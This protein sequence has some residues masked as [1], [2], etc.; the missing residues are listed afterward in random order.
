MR[1]AVI[2]KLAKADDA[3]LDEFRDAGIDVFPVYD[4]VTSSIE[5]TYPTGQPDKRTAR[6][7]S[8]AHPFF[9]NDM[10]DIRAKTVHL[11]ACHHVEKI[12]PS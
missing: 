10:P 4:A 3:M 5:L 9:I 2:T 7:H 1:T 8:I 11:Y 6:F 12:F